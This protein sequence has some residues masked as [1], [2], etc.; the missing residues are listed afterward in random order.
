M[1][2]KIIISS[3]NLVTA[4]CVMSVLILLGLTSCVGKGDDEIV[5]EQIIDLKSDDETRSG[6]SQ[7][8][9][10]GV[11]LLENGGLEIWNIVSSNHMPD[12]WFCHNNS[13]VKR[14]HSIVYEGT[15]SAK[16][17]AQEKG[18]SAIIDQRIAV[19]PGHKIRILFRYYVEQWK[20]NGART[21]CYFR[22]DAAEKY[23]ISADELK[24]FYGKDAYY[25]IRGGGYGLTY[26]PH[27]LN[28]WQTFDET[29]EVPPTAYYFVFGVNSYYGATIYVDDCYVIDVTEQTPTGIQ[30][31]HI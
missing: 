24:T 22:T 25:V 30:D 10:S 12:G 23:N 21:Y 9:P 6:Q 18:N 4:F 26:F 11:N 19:S 17:E 27:E 8:E 16:M 5:E 3:R 13:N 29:I 7:S 1:E 15:F 28:V 20:T 2:Y 14:N 31:V